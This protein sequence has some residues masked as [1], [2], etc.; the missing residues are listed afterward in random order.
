M[1]HGGERELRCRNS[2]RPSDGRPS[3]EPESFTR[4]RSADQRAPNW[5]SSPTRAQPRAWISSDY[6][7][8]WTPASTPAPT[9][10]SAQTFKNPNLIPVV[11]R[12][13][14]TRTSSPPA[15][16]SHREEELDEEQLPQIWRPSTDDLIRRTAHDYDLVLNYERD[17]EG[18]QRWL[19][20]DIAT[21]RDVGKNL[22]RDIFALRRRQ[23]VIAKLGD[24]DKD[25]IIKAKRAANLVKLL[26]ERVQRAINKYEQKCEFELLRDGAYEQDEDGN[27]YKPTTPQFYGAEADFQEIPYRDS[28]CGE[29]YS[30]NRRYNDEQRRYKDCRSDISRAQ[31]LSELSTSSQTGDLSILN[32]ASRPPAFDQYEHEV[33]H[34]RSEAGRQPKSSHANKVLGSRISKSYQNTSA[35]Q[36]GATS[37]TPQATS[38]DP[39][40]LSPHI[41]T[42][43]KSRTRGHSNKFERD[44]RSRRQAKRDAEQGRS[45]RKIAGKLGTHMLHY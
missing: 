38:P 45:P 12:R 5:S 28:E 31:A 3:H 23:R 11:P 33:A 24:Q 39:E 40:I 25:M 42:D 41:T 1:A 7:E 10:L 26:C 21:I 8:R 9:E 29:V 32:S 4:L 43:K 22:H 44:G 20:E 19:P 18:G 17:A 36:R 6:N 37:S 30:T 34:P 14:Y 13:S 15:I 2:W 16:R 35:H 27:F